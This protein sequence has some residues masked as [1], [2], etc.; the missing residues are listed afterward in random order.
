M[1]SGAN[2]GW[3]DWEG[4]FRFISRREVSLVDPRGEPGLAW[5]VVEYGQLDPLLGPRS[6]ATGLVVYRDDAIPQLENRLLFG[7]GPNGEV[8]HLDADAL[9]EGGQDSIRRVLFE[10]EGETR[11]F[12]Q[13]IREKNVEQGRA[14]TSRADVRI[15]TGPD[16]RIFLL[17]KHDGVIRRLVP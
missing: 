13:L 4:S 16:G 14:P 8:F 17:N 6:H 3:N 11:T 15:D 5:P 10:H 1:W 9:P 2:L 7:D 12:L